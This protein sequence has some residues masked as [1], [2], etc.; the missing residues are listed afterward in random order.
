MTVDPVGSIWLVIAAALVLAP[1][2]AIGPR[3]GWSRGKRVTLVLLRGATLLLLIALLLR[4]AIE[5]VEVKRLP[6]T[7]LILPDVSRSMQ[8]EDSLNDGSRY[9]AM[10]NILAS[11]ESEL[12]E[13][14]E[15]WDIRAYAFA[16][17]LTPVE[18]TEGSL[19]LPDKPEGAQSAIGSAIEDALAR[20]SQ[21]QRI[22]AV[23]LLSDGAQRAF[24]PRDAAPQDAVTSLV[25]Y[26]VPLYTFAFGKPTLGQQSDLRLSD[27]MSND[28]VFADAPTTVEAVVTAGGFANQVGTVQL[29]WESADGEMLPVD[30][31]QIRF[32][33]QREQQRVKLT[34]TPRE[35]GEY[36]LTLRVESP[37]GEAVTANNEQSTFVTVLAGG[38]NVL[39]LAGASRVGGGPGIEPR[40]VVS[41][42]AAHADMHVDYQLLNYRTPRISYRQQLKEKPYDAFLLG[43]VDV[44]A[45]DNRSWQSMADEVA[46]GAGL[47]MLGGFHS[48]GPGGFRGSPLKDALPIEMGPAERQNFGE[49]VRTDMHVPGPLTLTPVERN[50]QVHPAL[51]LRER[52]SE[53]L[54]A[55]NEL[56]P[57]DGANALDPLR[58]K[59][60]AQTVAWSGDDSRHPLLVLGAWGA[61][62]TAALAV[63][64]TWHWQLEGYGET[65]RRFWR[66][67]VLWLAQKDNAKGQKVWVQLDSRRFQQAS[68]VEF[69]VGA[70]DEAGQPLP[71]AAFDVQIELPDGTTEAVS[72][73][74]RGNEQVGLFT[75]TTQPGDYRIVVAARSGGETLQ[76]TSARFTVS[77]EDVELDQPAAEPTLLANLATMT[78]DAGGAGM[79]PE[80][81]PSVLDELKERT[82]EFEDR[83][84][85]TKTLWDTWP[86]LLGFVGLLGTEWY[87]RKRW[88]LV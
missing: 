23:L 1:L 59:P 32:S 64:S 54:E 19:A 16:Q 21:Q 5:T 83:I 73:V 24:A 31:R 70:N 55:W 4:P 58:I 47:A 77:D 27:L 62:R 43:N 38:V 14:A 66:Q 22:A 75:E 33:R 84:T 40:F 45:L 11:A 61:G 28:R 17:E 63:D 49:K 20:E 25:D 80:E 7:L 68:R 48:F 44:T 76:S 88:G 29:L 6:G 10:L 53:D 35:P 13:L 86:V 50:G 65:H 60:N 15:T 74:Q 82:K 78:S 36:K 12:A 37:V 69:R 42:L 52:P 30:T 2:L 41:A 85:E 51:R 46:Q 39:Y 18:V 56:P 81:L 67:L 8:V 3:R 79:A 9:D 34:H 57:L 72:T 71:S 87:L 26:G